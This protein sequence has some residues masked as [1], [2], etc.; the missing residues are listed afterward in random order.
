MENKAENKN[1]EKR[2]GNGSTSHYRI[3]D[4]KKYIVHTKYVFKGIFEVVAKNGTDALQKVVDDCGLV[5]GGN[6]HSTLPADTIDWD[7]SIHPE[8]RIVD[9]KPLK[10]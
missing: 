4:E 9:I 1:L 3:N 2:N 5:L 8:T 7:F 6:I 10:Q